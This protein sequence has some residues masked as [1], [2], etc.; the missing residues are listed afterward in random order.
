MYKDMTDMELIQKYTEDKN[1]LAFNELYRRYNQLLINS[2]ISKLGLE[3]D[4]SEDLASEVWMMLHRKLSRFHGKSSFN[5]WLFK[6]FHNKFLD[7]QRVG[8]MNTIAE[9][10]EIKSIQGYDK[11]REYDAKIVE[12]PDKRVDD[13]TYI[14]VPMDFNSLEDYTFN[15]PDETMTP[16]DEMNLYRVLSKTYERLSKMER[17][18][19]VM[20]LNGNSLKEVALELDRSYAHIK[21]INNKV[22]RTIREEIKNA[23]LGDTDE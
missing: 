15:F 5:T 9:R 18:V 1:E 22:N 12:E 20:L 3:P 14:H 4:L 13:E 7:L 6:V 2:G 19:M 23:N 10:L 17:R 11:D 16:E 21:S 8:Y